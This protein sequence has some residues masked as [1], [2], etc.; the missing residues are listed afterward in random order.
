MLLK[1]LAIEA[2]FLNQGVAW[3]MVILCLVVGMIG[4]FV[5]FI[6]GHL[7]IVL[8]GVFHWLLLGEQSG[9]SWVSLLILI[10]LLLIS[11]LFE[12]WSGAAA[13]R[14]FGGSVWGSWGAFIGGIV[15]LLFMPWGVF[16]GP[17]LGCGVGEF[18]FAKRR[19]VEVS[20]SA[21]GALI[22]TTMGIVLRIL[23]GLA[24]SIYLLITIV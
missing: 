6:P 10:A 11:Q 8:A 5:P 12:L 17:L 15:G 4:C 3:S 14:W 16:L 20:R 19:V 13:S 24:M 2:L 1:S 9:V 7:C 21:T 22:G 23:I 18:V